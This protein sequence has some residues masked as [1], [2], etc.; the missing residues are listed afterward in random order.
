MTNIILQHF[1]GDLRPLDELSV[2]NISAYAKMIGAEYR[3]IKGKPF[4]KR[5]TGE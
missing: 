4:N 5:L 1:D 2:E 3:L